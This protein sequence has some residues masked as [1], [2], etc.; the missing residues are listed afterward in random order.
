M[1]VMHLILTPKVSVIIPI[2]KV[3]KYIEK[4]ARSLFEQ[5]LDD[6]EYI[7]VDDCSPDNSVEVLLSLLE[8]Y[9]RRKEQ[10]RIIHHPQNLGL[11][12]ARNTG[13]YAA[14]GQ[15][16]AHC[17]SDDW[18]DTRYYEIMYNEASSTNSDI[19]Y[20][21]LMMVY[22]NESCIYQLPDWTADRISSFKRYLSSSWTCLVTTLVKRDLYHRYSLSSPTHI[23]FC[24]DFWLTVRLFY[25]ADRIT[26]INLPLYFYNRENESSILHLLNDKS[27]KE[28]IACYVETIAFFK[29][30]GVYEQFER[31]MMWRLLKSTA[32]GLYHDCIDIY[33]KYYFE[34]KKYIIS[35][36][37]INVKTKILLLLWTIGVKT[38][39]LIFLKLRKIL[40]R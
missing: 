32:D 33:E 20:C 30:N 34:S 11:S 27:Q 4:C 37:Y 29:E 23:A 24:E 40:G 10:I 15:Y 35:C 9:P 1:S 31:E 19:V 6:I 26:K 16:V 2:Y 18:L 8:E 12:C 5:T 21:D 14:R 17:D 38:P 13:L 25:Y 36:P 28:E 7:F 39:V 3:E 22:S